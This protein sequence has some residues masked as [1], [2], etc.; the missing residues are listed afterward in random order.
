MKPEA[1]IPIFIIG[2]ISA[3]FLI[4]GIKGLI[5]RKMIVNNPLA[6]N[7]PT[8][9][10]DAIIHLMQKKVTQD[11]PVPEGFI[12]RTKLVEIKGRSL[13]IRA[14][15]NIFFGLIALFVMITMLNPELFDLAMDY[16]FGIINKIN[17]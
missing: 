16:A 4:R 1:F 12:N 10:T 9:P 17:A 6:I 15:L 8:S 13:I 3:F 5:L 7:S 14:C 2:L 11:Y